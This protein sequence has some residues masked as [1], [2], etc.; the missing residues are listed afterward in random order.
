MDHVRVSVL[1]HGDRGGRVR[2]V[3]DAQAGPDG[4]GVTA[5]RTWSVISTN[6]LRA[7]V[8]TSNLVMAI[9]ISTSRPRAIRPL[10]DVSWRPS[11]RCASRWPAWSIPASYRGA[12]SPQAAAGPY[13]TCSS[14]RPL[15]GLSMRKL[16]ASL[17]VV[18]CAV[19]RSGRR[20]AEGWDRQRGPTARCRDGTAVEE[21]TLTNKNGVT[22]KVITLRRHRDRA[23][24]AGQGR[25]ARGRLS[26]LRASRSTWRAIRTS[27][28]SPAGSATASPRASSRSTARNTRWRPTTGRITCTAARKAST[29]RLDGRAG[30]GARTDSASDVHEQGRRGRLPR[31]LSRDRY[32]HPQRRQRVAHRLQ[33][34]HRQGDAGQPDPPQLLQ[35]GRA[36]LGRRSSS[37]EI[38]SSVPRNTRRRTRR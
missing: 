19:S 2:A 23:A 34:D 38:M 25:Q 22:M 21:Y 18:L 24:R 33:R 3:D 10:P 13:N 12:A 14:R 7:L 11:P 9:T 27:A 26:R 8:F 30:L 36:R 20:Q 35:S 4:R 5:A 16:L 17:A 32:L 29:R 31:Q 15:R 1:V 6:W 28:P 37:H